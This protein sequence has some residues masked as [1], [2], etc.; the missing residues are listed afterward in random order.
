[1]K[2]RD[3]LQVSFPVTLPVSVWQRSLTKLGGHWLQWGLADWLKTLLSLPLP[4]SLGC[5]CTITPGVT[6]THPSPCLGWQVH[7]YHHAKGNRYTPTSMPGFYMVLGIQIQASWWIVQ[8]TLEEPRYLPSSYLKILTIFIWTIW[9]R[10]WLFEAESLR[11]L[12][13][14]VTC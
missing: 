4:P 13:C 12:G 9:F 8:Q 3:W 2:A 7:T 5:T 14:S 11:N 10:F 6:D 1:M